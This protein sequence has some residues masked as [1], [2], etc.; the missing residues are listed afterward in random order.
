MSN[1]VIREAFESRLTAWAA[2]QVPPLPIA[3]ENR[4]FSPPLNNRYLRAYLIPAR[5]ES[6]YLA[7]TDRDYEG[8]FQISIVLPLSAGTKAASTIASALDALYAPSFIEGSTRVYLTSPMSEA[9]G[10]IEDNAYVLPVSCTYRVV[11]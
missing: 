3:Y 10:I 8:V 2:L 7:K 11:V 6:N 5:T 9:Q 4:T 1:V